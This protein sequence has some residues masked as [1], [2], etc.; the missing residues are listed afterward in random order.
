MSSMFFRIAL[1]LVLPGLVA[2]FLLCLMTSWNKFP[3]ALYLTGRAAVTLPVAITGFNTENGVLW[4]PMR[5][6][7]T[8]AIVPVFVFSFDHRFQETHTVSRSTFISSSARRSYPL[9]ESGAHC[10]GSP[11]MLITPTSCWR[12]AFPRIARSIVAGATPHV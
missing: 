1:P 8:I 7:G 4:G 3:F 9:N 12:R 2:A 5:A 10:G 11:M 6:A